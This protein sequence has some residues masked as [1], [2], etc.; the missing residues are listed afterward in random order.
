M[1]G[2][3]SAT[4][5][6][7]F[8]NAL[9]TGIGAAAAIDLRATAVVEL[10]PVDRS[11][12][13]RF[14]ADPDCDTPLARATVARACREF[15]RSQSFHVHLSVNSSIP[16]AKGLKSS[17]AV[18]VAIARAVANALEVRAPSDA[19]AR[20]SA[21]V[22]QSIGLSATGAFDDAMAAA[23]GGIVV[24]ENSSRTV[25]RQAPAPAEW[26]VILWTGS[27]VHAPSPEW[28]DRF[29]SAAV[30]G[31][32]AVEAARRGEWIAAMDANTR[33]VESLTGYHLTQ[34]RDQLRRLGALTSGVSG[35]GPALAT[36]VPRGSLES[37]ARA[38]P[39]GRTAVQLHQFVPVGPAGG[40]AD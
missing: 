33:I 17:S 8:A 12:T 39:A 25:L 18:S 34:W 14:A 13:A 29:Q 36:I 19:V 2:V 16:P 22:S 6:I 4:G 9:F 40:R 30:Q 32:V 10:E 5:A 37:V 24:T 3:G 21:N 11:G 1:R 15:A 20:L 28:S 31:E 26:A 7:T 35:L 27:G 38:H 23:D